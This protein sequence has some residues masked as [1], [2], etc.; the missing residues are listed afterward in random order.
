MKDKFNII[1]SIIIII[2]VALAVGFHIIP[3]VIGVFVN[4][5]IGF[6]LGKII[7]KRM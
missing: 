5:L 7:I 1:S 6:S 3:M 2:M 4:F